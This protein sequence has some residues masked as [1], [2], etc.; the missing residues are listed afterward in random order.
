MWRVEFSQS[1]LMVR[2]AV[3]AEK[4]DGGA[5]WGLTFQSEAG[6]NSNVWESFHVK[7]RYDFEKEDIFWIKKSAL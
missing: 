1:Q 2:A 4:Q 7:V 5:L 6:L 3:W